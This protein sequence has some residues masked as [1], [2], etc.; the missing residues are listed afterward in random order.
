MARAYAEPKPKRLY[1]PQGVAWAVVMESNEWFDGEDAIAASVQERFLRD[2]SNN[3]RAIVSVFDYRTRQ[4]TE[5]AFMSY[6]AAHGY[7]V[8]QHRNG[9]YVTVRADR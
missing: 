6:R 1:G 8:E 4:T 5:R 2:W 9:G 7:A 3:P